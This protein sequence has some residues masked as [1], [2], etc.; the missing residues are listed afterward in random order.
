MLTTPLAAE[1]ATRA[2]RAE[3]LAWARA[4]FPGDALRPALISE[5]VVRDGVTVVCVT[6]QIEGF[7]GQ[8]ARTVR[9]PFEITAPGSVARR[10]QSPRQHGHLQPAGHRL[11]CLPRSRRGAAVS[12][13]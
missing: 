4:Y 3:I 11:A 8:P 12:G 9:Q 13:F 6:F 2:D 7:F 10:A 1:P 5:R